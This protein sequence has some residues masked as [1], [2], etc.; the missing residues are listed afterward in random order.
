[1]ENASA[2]ELS[3][4]VMSL[5]TQTSC[6][7]S[8]LLRRFGYFTRN[9]V[10]AERLIDHL[11]HAL[12]NGAAVPTIYGD[13]VGRLHNSSR[14]RSGQREPTKEIAFQ[15]SVSPPLNMFPVCV[16]RDGKQADCTNHQ[17]TRD[18]R[19]VGFGGSSQQHWVRAEANAH[20]FDPLDE[21]HDSCEFRNSLACRVA[22]RPG[23][24]CPTGAGTC[25][26]VFLKSMPCREDSKSRG[27]R[28]NKAKHS[29]A[30][31]RTADSGL[32]FELLR[33]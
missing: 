18:Y 22:T 1:M 28:R 9:N 19:T 4:R 29:N 30:A 21:P 5:P 33:M 17:T 10:A 26:D 32:M 13:S 6:L 14:I 8:A 11:Y 2:A 20:R 3:V 27:G 31:C 25:A 24:C 12:L 16:G 15:A 23:R 7:H